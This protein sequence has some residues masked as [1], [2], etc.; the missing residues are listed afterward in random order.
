[1]TTLNTQGNLKLPL[2]SHASSTLQD[3]KETSADSLRT[4][5]TVSLRSVLLEPQHGGCCDTSMGDGYARGCL[6]RG[7]EYETAAGAQKAAPTG[8][9]PPT[10]DR[11]D[12]IPWLSYAASGGRAIAINLMP[13][14]MHLTVLSSRGWIS[15]SRSTM[16]PFSRVTKF[17]FG[18]HIMV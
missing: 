2:L 10:G 12:V 1:M 16:K 3:Y 14:R 5:R 8:G 18:C 4:V 7:E 9:E 13:R 11:G 17:F 15:T 6:R